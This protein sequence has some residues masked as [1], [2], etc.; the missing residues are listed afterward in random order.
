MVG[1]TKWSNLLDG[2]KADTHVSRWFKYCSDQGIFKAVNGKIALKK[3]SK[4]T[5]E[6]DGKKVY[7]YIYYLVL[8]LRF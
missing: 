8:I 4:K 2:G 3:E 7:I 1:N 5:S 6:N